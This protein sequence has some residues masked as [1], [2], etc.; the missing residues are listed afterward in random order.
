MAFENIPHQDDAVRILRAVLSSGRMPHALLFLGPDG[1]GRA[2]TAHELARVA[3]CLEPPGP[4]DYCGCCASCGQMARGTHPDFF[5]IAVRE[6][7][8]LISIGQ[9]RDA[10]HRAALK[11]VLGPRRVVLVRQTERLSLE[12]AN[13]FLKT[14]EEPPG[15]CLLILLAASVREIPQTVVSRCRLVRFASLPADAVAEGLRADGVEPDQAEWLA[16]RSGGSPG[17]AARFRRM[18]LH[19]FNDQLAERLS[20][21]TVADNFELSAWLDAAAASGSGSAGEAREILQ[22]LIECVALYY[23]DLTVA[24]SAVHDSLARAEMA[25]EAIEKID[26]N[27]NR[28]LTLDNLFTQLARQ[29]TRSA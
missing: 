19:L 20:N 15:N 8:R 2:R 24:G 6:N 16:R 13:A 29:T 5:P 12:A 23:R 7:R 4:A 11:P 9:I 21:L 18:E 14:L 3:V 22:E 26:G 1:T 17:A 25:L 10:Q 28:R 27:A